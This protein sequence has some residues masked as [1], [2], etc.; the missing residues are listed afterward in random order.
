[1]CFPVIYRDITEN[2]KSNICRF[3][4]ILQV[5]IEMTKPANRIIINTRFHTHT[6]IFI[7]TIKHVLIYVVK[8]YYRQTNNG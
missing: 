8:M 5:K 7:L 3:Y 4:Q 6:L 1:M 2:N